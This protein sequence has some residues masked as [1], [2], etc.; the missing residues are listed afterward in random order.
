MK[1]NEVKI[2]RAVIADDESL[3]AIA[4]KR[5]LESNGVANIKIVGNQEQLW[6]EIYK[7][8]ED[9]NPVDLIVSDM[10]YPLTRGGDPDEECG[11]KLIERL[12]EEGIK[13]PVIICSS[14]NYRVPEALGCVWYNKLNDVKMAFRE[15][16][17]RL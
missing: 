3:K 6:E 13:I 11:F 8:R 4:I 16:L 14:I 15:V 9:G 12:K 10:Q 1:N 2:C 7:S 17:G 5:A